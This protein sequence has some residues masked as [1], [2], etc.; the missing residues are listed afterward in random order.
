M[1]G[2]RIP[3]KVVYNLIDRN[4][5]TNANCGLL[6]H[7]SIVIELERRLTTILDSRTKQLNRNAVTQNFGVNASATSINPSANDSL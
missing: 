7:Q 3:D 5:P 2:H 6:R 1:I 4:I